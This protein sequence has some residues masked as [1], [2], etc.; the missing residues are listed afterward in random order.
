MTIVNDELNSLSK[1]IWPWIKDGNRLAE[2]P[3]DIQE[4]VRHY[5]EVYAKAYDEELRLMG[6]H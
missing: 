2:A 6:I 5:K 3:E 1:D 4:K